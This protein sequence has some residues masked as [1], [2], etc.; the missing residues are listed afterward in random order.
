[1]NDMEVIITIKNADANLP[2]IDAAEDMREHIVDIFQDQVEDPIEVIVKIITEMPTGT[3]GNEPIVK[4]SVYSIDHIK[5]GKN[6]RFPY[7]TA[8]HR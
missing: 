4:R 1:M 6:D 5:E 7:P 2:M 8:Q 3:Y